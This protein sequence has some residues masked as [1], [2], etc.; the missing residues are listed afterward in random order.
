MP[1]TEPL[2]GNN[3]QGV[4]VTGKDG[5]P[6]NLFRSDIGDGSG[7]GLGTEKFGG[8]SQQGQ[9][10]VTEDQFLRRTQQH[11]FWLDVPVNDVL[12]MRILESGGDLLDVE[13]HCSRWEMR[14]ARIT[15]AYRSSWRIVHNKDRHA[16][17]NG[18]LKN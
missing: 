10:K 6:S 11:V 5:F 9:P 14:T 1:A 15:V 12:V 3:G 8:R 7:H 18:V 17:L 2:V 16:L 13:G 4:L